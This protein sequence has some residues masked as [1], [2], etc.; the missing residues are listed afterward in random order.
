M[1]SPSR[2]QSPG[3]LSPMQVD[4]LLA[5]YPN[6]PTDFGLWQLVAFR[7]VQQNF[8][9]VVPAHVAH[10]SVP[11]APQAQTARRGRGRGTRRGT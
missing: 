3:D 6:P 2:I 9:S 11:L 8:D 10:L 7:V 4:A 5:D 1:G